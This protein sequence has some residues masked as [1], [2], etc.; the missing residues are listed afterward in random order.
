MLQSA[1]GWS[2]SSNARN[3]IEAGIKFEPVNYRPRLQFVPF[4]PGYSQCNLLAE[5]VNRLDGSEYDA[6]L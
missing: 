1:N 5:G 4:A 2:S 3:G 6:V